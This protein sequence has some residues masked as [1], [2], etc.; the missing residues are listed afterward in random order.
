MPRMK[1]S[2]FAILKQKNAMMDANRVK[3]ARP[4]EIKTVVLG[5]EKLNQKS[6]KDSMKTIDSTGK[7]V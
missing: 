1:P 4:A 3:T 5:G 2:D 6:L 7:R